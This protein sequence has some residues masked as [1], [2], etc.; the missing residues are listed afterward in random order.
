M[1][2]PKAAFTLIELLVV[3]LILGILA[4]L[5]V[6]QF[7]LAVE[8][9]RATEALH[10]LKAIEQAGKICEMERGERCVLDQLAIMLPQM[11]ELSSVQFNSDHFSYIGWPASSPSAMR[12]NSPTYDYQLYLNFG[13]YHT[14]RCIAQLEK[15]KQIC[16]ALGGREVERL[17]E[18][19][20]N[21]SDYIF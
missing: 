21:V 8:K 3:V 5:A 19:T 7:A 6:P 4:A 1:H 20:Y 2:S 10:I 16:K 15:G 13:P 18:N 12:I 9:S 17:T 11:K 14:R